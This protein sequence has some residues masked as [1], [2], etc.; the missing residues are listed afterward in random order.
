M[1]MHILR[2][3]SLLSRSS[4]K[5]HFIHKSILELE[6]FFARTIY[7]TF[8]KKVKVNGKVL[9]K[10]KNLFHDY[11]VT[12]IAAANAITILVK[13]RVVFSNQDLNDVR[14]SGADLSYGVFD[15]AQFQRA[16]LS[17][18]NLQGAWL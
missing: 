10:T 1:K 11:S 6:Y 15:Y 14:I 18:V 12:Q 16:D 13:A 5:Y 7:E 3:S 17:M 2:F 8:T 9:F 4:N